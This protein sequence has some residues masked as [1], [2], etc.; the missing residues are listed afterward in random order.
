MTL[1]NGNSGS[2]LVGAPPTRVLGDLVAGTWVRDAILVIA[3]AV[4]VGL[5]AQVTVPLPFTP[6][7]LTGQT[8][9]VLLA[10]AAL[11]WRRGAASMALYALAGLAGL[12][13]FASHAG[14][15][16]ILAGPLFGYVLAYPLAAGLV[17]W[18]SG[19]GLDRR[20][21]RTFA[22]MIAGSA[23]IY[24]GG[25]PWLMVSLHVG[26]AR[27]LHLGVTPFLPGD[28]L[29]ALAAACLLPASWALVSRFR[30]GSGRAGRA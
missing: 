29:K 26:L 21:L 16:A 23:V 7:P 19:R 15:T 28:A 13:W 25:L 10:G 3:G 4:L 9:G 12:P 14:G 2:G 30:P 18:L 8:F 1:V 27:G 6:V 22:M 17:G 24:A 5:C 20:P 11:G